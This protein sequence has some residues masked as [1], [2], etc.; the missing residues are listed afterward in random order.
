VSYALSCIPDEHSQIII[1]KTED[2][3]E[4]SRDKRV[5]PARPRGEGQWRVQRQVDYVARCQLDKTR[6]AFIEVCRCL[7]LD[8]AASYNSFLI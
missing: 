4:V 1:E 3:N 8:A 2:A 5:R 6:K 7:I